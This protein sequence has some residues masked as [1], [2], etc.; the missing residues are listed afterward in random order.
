MGPRLWVTVHHQTD[1]TTLLPVYRDRRPLYNMPPST[2][3]R[4]KDVRHTI[5]DITKALAVLEQT[6]ISRPVFASQLHALHKL[7]GDLILPLEFL[8][9][10]MMEGRE[11]E[12]EHSHYIRDCVALLAALVPQMD[13]MSQEHALQVAACRRGAASAA[14]TVLWGVLFECCRAYCNWPATMPGGSEQDITSLLSAFANLLACFL[15]LTHNPTAWDA[16]CE[17]KMRAYTLVVIIRAALRCLGT[18]SLLPQAAS[19]KC[20]CS[21]PTDFI[22]DLCCIVSEQLC[23]RCL[24]QTGGPGHPQPGPSNTSNKKQIPP[25]QCPKSMTDLILSGSFYPLVRLIYK[26]VNAQDV[27]TDKRL[28]QIMS[29]PAVAHVLKKMVLSHPPTDALGESDMV[30]LDFFISLA[31]TCL[32]C[33]SQS[34]LSFHVSTAE[35]QDMGSGIPINASCPSQYACDT[36]DRQLLHFL[37][38]GKAEMA[39]G[40]MIRN[41]VR[42]SITRA[43]LVREGEDRDMSSLKK[44]AW[45]LTVI[46]SLGRSAQQ[47]L[48]HSLRWMQCLQMER[49]GRSVLQDVEVFGQEAT[50]PTSLL[51]VTEL[52]MSQGE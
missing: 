15:E 8:E 18:I 48:S 12:Q 16:V 51:Q 26:F 6:P 45:V 21:L 42:F 32:V 11:L 40:C 50:L 39:L 19:F 2:A 44:A 5:R 31:L 20:M 35:P 22:P 38:N 1:P 3:T 28:L 33:L 24:T 9:P 17:P 52:S 4:C 37:C 23:G 29:S 13:R 43:W 7:H 46:T 41:R 49:Q 34:V 14:L 47:C 36:V 25:E 27:M 30:S 10:C